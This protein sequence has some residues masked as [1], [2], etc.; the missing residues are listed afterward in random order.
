MSKPSRRSILASSAGL[1]LAALAARQAEAATTP[2]VAPAPT[3]KSPRE[4]TRLDLG[5]KFRL[6]HA[7]DVDR[8]FGFGAI[9]SGYAKAGSWNWPQT[10]TAPYYNDADWAPVD[11]PHD[12]AIELPFVQPAYVD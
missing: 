10:P 6:G 3:A 12:W 11:L 9:Q 2:G 8:D 4:T 5:W 1:T 7:S